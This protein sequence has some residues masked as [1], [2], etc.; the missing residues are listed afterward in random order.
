MPGPDKSMSLQKSELS[1][2]EDI[3]ELKISIDYVNDTDMM[4]VED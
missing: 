2:L 1:E 3:C 4:K